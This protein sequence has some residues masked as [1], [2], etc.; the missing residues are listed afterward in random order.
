MAP[1]VYLTQAPRLNLDVSRAET[2]GELVDLM[3]SGRLPATGNEGLLAEL[4]EALEP[5][6]AEKD[7]ILFLGDSSIIL[8][9]GLIL[10]AR[11]VRMLRALRW[12]A[13]REGYTVVCIQL[14]EAV[15]G[16]RAPYCSRCGN[17]S[18]GTKPCPL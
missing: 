5:F 8:A 18:H 4:A 17:A 10:G 13:R 11:G 1:K 6:D 7:Y 16:Q 2:F 9:V 15:G 3:D 12:D 14:P